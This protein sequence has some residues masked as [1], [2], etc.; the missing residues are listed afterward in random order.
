[1]KWE[2]KT[3]ILFRTVKRES[4]DG[5]IWARYNR[6]IR[7]GKSFSRGNSGDRIVLNTFGVSETT[8]ETF[9][10]EFCQYTNLLSA[11]HLF[12]I[13][14]NSYTVETLRIIQRKEIVEL[15][16]PP[17]LAERTKFIHELDNWR[18]AQ[19]FPD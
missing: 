12:F 10:G 19:V 17:S 18:V 1:M 14:V 5:W 7:R 4:E 11:Q 2:T 16:P 3:A 8:I 9:L 15:I 6:R 13:S